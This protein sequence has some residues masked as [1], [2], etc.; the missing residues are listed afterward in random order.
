MGRMTDA[1]FSR[2]FN[3]YFNLLS[4]I[5]YSYTLNKFDAEDVVQEVF[6]K[7]YRINKKFNNK[8][9]EKYW[10]IRVTINKSLDFIKQNKKEV[11]I[12]NE[13]INILQNSEDNKK[14][15]EI[16]DCVC[17][18]KDNYKTIIIL[19]YYNNYNIKEISNILKISE[20]NVTTRLNRA[21]KKLKDIITERIQKWKIKN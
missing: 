1:E 9:E 11:L 15:E 14:N 17:S 7:Y 5:A 19:F 3:E 13:S 6:I 10:L 18:L 2:A 8:L 20:S 16:Y 4:N 12:N 21:K